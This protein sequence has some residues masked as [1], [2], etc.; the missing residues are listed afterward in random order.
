[1]V[2][3]GLG[4][5][6][7][8]GFYGRYALS[9]RSDAALGVVAELP[10]H[11]NAAYAFG[12]NLEFRYHL[13]LGRAW[14]LLVTTR[15]EVL[16]VSPG[17][18]GFGSSD[19]FAHPESS[20]HYIGTLELPFVIGSDLALAFGPTV[21]FATG[22]GVSPQPTLNAAGP[23]T[24]FVGLI[25]AVQG[26]TDVLDFGISFTFGALIQTPGGSPVALSGTAG[27]FLAGTP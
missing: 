22:L 12:S 2:G 1:M 4:G 26:L 19:R 5:A 16:G 3:P 15:H 25:V 7:R 6:V 11:A 13:W 23:G 8:L 17:T 14:K 24:V 20:I 18:L 9:D 10:G 27:G 21:S